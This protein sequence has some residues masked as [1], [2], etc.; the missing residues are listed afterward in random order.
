M[1]EKI[2]ELEAWLAFQ[3]S[4]GNRGS[5]ERIQAKIAYIKAT[6]LLY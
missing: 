4:Q 6:G 1:E 5:V 3:R 2:K